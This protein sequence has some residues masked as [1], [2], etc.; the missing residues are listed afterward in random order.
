LTATH[1]AVAGVPPADVVPTITLAS[2]AENDAE[3]TVPSAKSDGLIA[4]STPTHNARL[5]VPPAAVEPGRTSASID[6]TENKETLAST[7]RPVVA[8]LING[9]TG[10]RRPILD[11]F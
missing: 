11:I 10:K 8:D 4:A 1:T 3:A 5:G 2:V 7:K 9:V 6:A